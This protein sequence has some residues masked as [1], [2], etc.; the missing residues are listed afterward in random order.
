VAIDALDCPT[1]LQFESSG[2]LRY[3]LFLFHSVSLKS[4]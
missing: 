4:V 1:R 2:L 3:A